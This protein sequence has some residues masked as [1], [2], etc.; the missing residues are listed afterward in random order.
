MGGLPR[1]LCASMRRH[2]PA[3]QRQ[4]V[5]ISVR[6]PAVVGA[7]ASHFCCAHCPEARRPN[8]DDARGASRTPV[9]AVPVH[10]RQ[11]PVLQPVAVLDRVINPH[12][13]FH[14]DNISGVLREVVRLRAPGQ[15]VVQKEAEEDRVDETPCGRN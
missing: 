5:P 13:L 15:R 12:E 14:V 7:R 8:E 6:P 2:T 4:L 9:D 10:P 11:E 3:H 1:L